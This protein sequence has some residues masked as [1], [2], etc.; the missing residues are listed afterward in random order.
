MIFKGWLCLALLGLAVSEVAVLLIEVALRPVWNG[1]FI[2]VLL[3]YLTG[4][5]MLVV[6]WTRQDAKHA[7]RDAVKSGSV[8]LTSNGQ[9]VT[10][11]APDCP[12][13]WLVILHVQLHPALLDL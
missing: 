13:R 8:T 4:T 9:L 11:I 7:Y 2:A 1:T 5:V 12:R 6:I 3:A 10:G